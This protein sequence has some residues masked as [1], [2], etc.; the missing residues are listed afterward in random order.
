MPLAPS[1]P[2]FSPPVITLPPRPA[3]SQPNVIQGPRGPAGK[4]GRDGRGIADLRI[5]SGSLVV[6]YSDGTSADL[7]LVVGRDGK[8]GLPG[9]AGPEGRTPE[10]D[11]EEIVN[12]LPPQMLRIRY[13]DKNGNELAEPQTVTAP[14][15]EPLPI[16][17]RYGVEPGAN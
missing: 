7:G 3:P 13:I 15:G 16:R 1:Q 9:I 10:I 12:N 4:D 11:Y 6:T 17:F 5:I 2:P 14:L 8:D